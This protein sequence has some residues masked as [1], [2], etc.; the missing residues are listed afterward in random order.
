MRVNNPIAA[1]KHI[2][3][4]SIVTFLL[5]IVSYNPS[6]EEGGQD[7]ISFANQFRNK[8]DRGL[9]FSNQSITQNG[10]TD[11]AVNEESEMVDKM[12]E[13]LMSQHYKFSAI[14]DVV[15]KILFLCYFVYLCYLAYNF[16]IKSWMRK[17]IKQKVI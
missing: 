13:Y 6:T 11:K 14:K 5:Y 15:W 4:L 12:M 9:K 1:K 10:A 2:T 17:G 3:I 16:F 8:F 7:A